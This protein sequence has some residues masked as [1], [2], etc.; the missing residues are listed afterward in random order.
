MSYMNDGEDKPNVLALALVMILLAIMIIMMLNSCCT[1]SLNNVMTSGV[2]KDVVD[3]EDS[4]RSDPDI[5]PTISL[6][7]NP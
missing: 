2:A 5:S 4:I 3:E 1:L 7:V 6:P